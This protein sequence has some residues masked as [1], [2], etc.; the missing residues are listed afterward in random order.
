[1]N[2][3]RSLDFIL[4]PPPPHMVGDGFRVHHFFPG[5][6]PFSQQRLS[7]FF[8]L[9]YNSAFEF[10]PTD[11]PR[12]VDVHPHRGFE[13]VTLVFKGKVAHHDNAGNSGVIGEG[14][15]Q[16]MTAG[17]GILHKEYHEEEYS[18]KG[19]TFHMA[20]LWVNLPAANKSTPPGYQEIT[21]RDIPE[22]SIEGGSVKIIAGKY[23][24]VKG[25]AKTFSP[26]ELYRI[27]MDKG[28]QHEFEI[29]VDYNCFLLCIDGSIL[30]K[31]GHIC[32][33]DHLAVYRND[34]EK[35]Q[36]TAHDNTDVIMFSGKPLNEPI[37]AYGPFVMNTQD[38]IRQALHDFREGKFGR[39][40]S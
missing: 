2:Q 27:K 29:P 14:E 39:P 20:Q 4:P 22:V 21:R 1:M 33:K 18:K 6:A 32:A 12:G 15:V 25:P 36:L 11:K 17:S 3:Y 7:P 5:N 8:M 35:A 34:G 30:F 16:W 13:T 9:D 19:G 28:H 26:I 23:L 38:E 24:G 37:A 40:L 31:D 10:P